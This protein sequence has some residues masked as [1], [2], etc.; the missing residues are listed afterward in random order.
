MC[1]GSWL[2]VL[3]RLSGRGMYPHQFAFVLLLP[4]RALILSPRKLVSRLHL[5][6]RSRVLE[7]GPGPGYFSVSV[8]RSIPCGHLYPVDFQSEMLDKA[9]R[10]L[11]RGCR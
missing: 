11:R 2:D 7:L 1:F 5:T 9:R 10:R 4:F 8:A 3:C 6:D